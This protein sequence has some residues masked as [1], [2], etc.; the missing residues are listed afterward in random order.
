MQKS[1]K[2]IS[3]NSSVEI[4]PVRR[5]KLSIALRNVSAVKSTGDPS[6]LSLENC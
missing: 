3:N 5:P 2:I 4:L 6:R 1:L